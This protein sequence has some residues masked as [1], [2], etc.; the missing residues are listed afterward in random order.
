MGDWQALTLETDNYN[1]EVSQEQRD[2]S[3]KVC[4][5]DQCKGTRS[6]PIPRGQQWIRTGQATDK[7]CCAWG[8]NAC[9][10]CAP[11]SE[12]QSVAIED[13]CTEL[14]EKYP[15]C[16]DDYEGDTPCEPS[17]EDL[18]YYKE[19]CEDP[20]YYSDS[21]DCN[22]HDDCGGETPFCYDGSC[23][24]CDQCEN[25]WD[26]IDGTCGPCGATTSGDTCEDEVGGGRPQPGDPSKNVP[27]PNDGSVVRKVCVKD[28]CKGTLT[29]PIPI[30][31]RWTDV[32]QASAKG[33]CKGW[34]SA[35]HW[36][37]NPNSLVG[38]QGEGK[39]YVKQGP[40]N[41][42]CEDTGTWEEDA[43]GR[44]YSDSWNSYSQCMARKWG[45]DQSCGTDSQ[46]CWAYGDSS[47]CGGVEQRVCH[48]DGCHGTLTNTIP[49]GQVWE[50]VV[51]QISSKGCCAFAGKACD[52]CRGRMGI[53]TGDQIYLRGSEGKHIEVQDTLAQARYDDRGDWQ[54]FTIEK[55]KEGNISSGDHVYLRSHTGKHLDVENEVAQARFDDHGDWQ[56]FQIVNQAQHGFIYKGDTVY[57]WSHT[58]MF[59]DVQDEKVRARYNEM[60]D[61][62]ALTLETDNYNPEVSQEQ[63]D[64]SKKVCYKDQCKGTRS[65]PLPR[66]QQW[67]RTGQAS[68]KGCCAWGRNACDWCAP[69]SAEE[70]VAVPNK[71]SVSQSISE[72]SSLS[73]VVLL[74]ALFGVGSVLYGFY[75]SFVKV[76]D[77]YELS[78]IAEPTFK[79]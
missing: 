32:G 22:S 63:R 42:N 71:D 45:N 38:N 76:S 10:W 23:D 12:E 13:H 78:D 49:M 31:Q 68:D 50:R 51:S 66:G 35:C 79:A 25:C 60:G 5:K 44:D 9:D 37:S 7:G 11:P 69:P 8:R 77:Y 17:D 41:G 39:C 74:L 30:G 73:N 40:G 34:K 46:W 65:N 55:D 6:N 24:T 21:A 70:G 1:P 16:D 19:N 43:W 62:Q 52:L 14:E 36:C 20:S 3:K 59:I 53:K 57:L 29:N 64:N 72:T 56:R 2:N 48:I 47:T 4:Y 18:D 15:E 33:C 54:R 27:E 58:G 75:Q 61:W 26:G 67:I 28:G